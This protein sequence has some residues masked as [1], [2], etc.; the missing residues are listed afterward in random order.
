M[1]CFIYSS[2]LQR[3]ISAESRWETFSSLYML[4]SCPATFVQ[5]HCQWREVRC[6]IITLAE[7]PEGGERANSSN[8]IFALAALA[9]TLLSRQYKY[10][11]SAPCF[12]RC[13][14]SLIHLHLTLQLRAFVPKERRPHLLSVHEAKCFEASRPVNIFLYWELGCFFFPPTMRNNALRVT[15]VECNG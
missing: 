2:H 5:L 12:H 13:T 8:A 9:S 15:L 1:L 14:N 10:L 7:G 11:I 3:E 6:L 4:Q